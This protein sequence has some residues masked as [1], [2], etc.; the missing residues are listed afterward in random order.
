MCCVCPL[1]TYFHLVM[2]VFLAKQRNWKFNIVGDQTEIITF[3]RIK[4]FVIPNGIN[5]WNIWFAVG[6]W[7]LLAQ[8]AMRL[9]SQ[10]QS[11]LYNNVE[12]SYSTPIEQEASEFYHTSYH[13]FIHRLISTKLLSPRSYR[14][15]IHKYDS[16]S[17][18]AIWIYTQALEPSSVLIEVCHSFV[19][20]C[21]N[22][23]TH[24]HA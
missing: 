12:E 9:S 5:E 18:H 20:S 10:L 21:T 17:L 13:N 1:S 22:P 14:K 19:Q 2:F 24:N 3:Y 8:A 16:C 6:R 7:K 4:I 11:I 23:C 15:R